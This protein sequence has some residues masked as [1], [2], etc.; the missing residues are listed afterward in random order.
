MSMSNDLFGKNMV[1]CCLFCTFNAKGAD[2]F[3]EKDAVRILDMATACRDVIGNKLL[4]PRNPRD[5][6][7]PAAANEKGNFRQAARSCERL[8]RSYSKSALN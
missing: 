6:F 4:Q 5:L 7:S 2:D 3:V 8:S 1:V